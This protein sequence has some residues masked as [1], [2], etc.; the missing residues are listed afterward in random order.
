MI[1]ATCQHHNLKPYTFQSEFRIVYCC[2][3]MECLSKICMAC[4]LGMSVKYPDVES[5][6]T[7]IA[8]RIGGGK[9]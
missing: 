3:V 4:I 9:G 7:I 1:L 6:R 5:V 2:L 8:E